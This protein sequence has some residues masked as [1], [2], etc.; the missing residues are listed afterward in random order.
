M[1]CQ[2]VCKQGRDDIRGKVN[3]Q[4]PIPASFYTCNVKFSINK[5]PRNLFYCKIWTPSGPP[6]TNERTQTL[7]IFHLQNLDQQHIQEVSEI[8]GNY[9]GPLVQQLAIH[10]SLIPGRTQESLSATSCKVS[11]F[12]L[13]FSSYK[14]TV[15][16]KSTQ[17]YKYE[18]KCSKADAEIIN[19]VLNS[20]RSMK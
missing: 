2:K 14:Q 12:V 4:S 18:T 7:E 9:S 5:D 3:L 15:F 13:F 1:A 10:C 20:A 19:R 17:K 16:D 11:F 6:S 8:S